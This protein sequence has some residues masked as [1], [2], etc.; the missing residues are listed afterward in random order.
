MIV[1][2]AAAAVAS[3]CLAAFYYRKG[4]TSQVKSFLG[5]TANITDTLVFAVR[6]SLTARY[7]SGGPVGLVSGS[8]S[9]TV[10]A[11]VGAL[12]GNSIQWA[13]NNSAKGISWPGRSNTPNGRAISVL[14][15]FRPG[16][17]GTPGT[18]QSIFGLTAMSGKTIN[19]SMQHLSTTGTVVMS[20]INESA[21][22]VLT[23]NS[24]G[25]WSPTSGT[26]YDIV[27]T[28]DGNTTVNGINVYIDGTLL[29]QATGGAAFAAGW[30][31]QY[32]SDIAL[33]SAGNQ[34]GSLNAGRM[35]E[36][37]IWGNVID[38]TAVVLD[39]GT[40]SLNGAART[41]LVAAAAFDG[42]AYSDPGIA[43]VKLNTTYSY[44]G[45]TLTGSLVSTTTITGVNYG[46]PGPMGRN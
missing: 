40:G 35:D 6:G 21:G 9:V 17:T 19:M 44:A 1:G 34:G 10:A 31:N 12:S 20:I 5:F 26:W 27:F 2:I 4:I 14:A 41:S 8:A 22:V 46:G 32:F 42:S 15:R 7:S 16:Y 36:F 39:S 29:G 3:V 18:S 45:V 13:A 43:N 37:V 33:G 11:D 25:A 38:P 23:A 30:T 24:F 28:W